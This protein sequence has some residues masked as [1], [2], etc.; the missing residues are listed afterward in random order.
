MNLRFKKKTN[1]IREFFKRYNKQLSL[2][3]TIA[4]LGLTFNIN[5]YTLMVSYLY[6]NYKQELK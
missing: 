3:Y 2:I 1:I 6:E 4:I 5:T